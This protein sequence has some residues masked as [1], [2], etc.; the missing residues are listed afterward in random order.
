MDREQI[1]ELVRQLRDFRTRSQAIDALAA[2]GTE[3]VGPLLT[4]LEM[5]SNEGARWAMI[6]CLGELG[7]SR[8]VPVLAS[9]LEQSDY[10]TV[11][12][13][14]LSKIVGRDLGPLPGDW[15]RWAELRPL[16]TGRHLETAYEAEAAEPLTNR[17]LVEL[18]LE[19]SAASWREEDSDKFVV[20]LPLA[21]GRTQRVTLAFGATDQEGGE[22]VIIY[23]DCGEANPAHY[24]AV[25]R[26]NL[27]MPYGAVA[28][29][30]VG[31]Q[32][33][34]VM[35][36]TILRHALSPIELRKSIF[37]IGERAH[38]VERQLMQ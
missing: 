18:A 29:R 4:A 30:D 37:T 9:F 5:E 7:E 1:H 25:L 33:C 13:E 36:N 2:A 3:A 28:L 12:R 35:F 8:A 22:I 31:E 15:L 23:S 38:R 6:H 20:N 10:Q 14:A 11:T 34:F 19:G 21:G 32:S 24:E 17:R 26:R 16:E 27:R